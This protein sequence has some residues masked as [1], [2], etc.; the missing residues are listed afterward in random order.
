MASASEAALLVV[1]GEADA[2]RSGRVN[3]CA[4]PDNVHCVAVYDADARTVRT[5]ESAAQQ[6]AQQC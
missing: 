2:R 4:A 1:L 6:L 5:G 3:V